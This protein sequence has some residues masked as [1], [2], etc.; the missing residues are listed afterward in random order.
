MRRAV[1]F[2]DA[3]VRVA[4]TFFGFRFCVVIAQ[5]PAHGGH[6]QHERE[7]GH[8]RDGQKRPA[9]EQMAISRASLV[10]R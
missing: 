8:Q 1:R 5:Q 9:I 10:R 7:H 6:D 4:R 3:I 2:L